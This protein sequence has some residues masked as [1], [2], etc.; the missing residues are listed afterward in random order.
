MAGLSPRENREV[1]PLRY[2][3]VHRLKR[4]RPAL[5]IVINGG[6]TSLGQ[7]REQLGHVDGVMMGREAYRNPF[8]LAGVDGTL[9]DD[10][11]PPPA[12][13]EVV[14]TMTRYAARRR[15]AGEPLHRVTRHMLGLF[16]GCPGARAWRRHLS[17][18]AHGAKADE[19]VLREALARL[20][21]PGLPSNTKVA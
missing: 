19:R 18:N 6:L 17:E 1:P 9:F 8:L 5:L 15:A 16:H 14:E 21:A 10:T 13:G 4:E 20:P 7:C 3:V 12:R 2:D 11:R